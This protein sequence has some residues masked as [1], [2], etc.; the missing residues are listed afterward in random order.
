VTVKE[1]VSYFC[2]Q[3]YT[4]GRK[5]NLT[6]DENF[7]DAIEQAE[8]KDKELQECIAKGADPDKE[9]GIFFG[10]PFS[11]KDQIYVKGTIS[12]MGVGSRADKVTDSDAASVELIR[13]QGGIPF[14]KG[15][16]SDC[17]IS[18]HSQSLIWGSAKHP[19]DNERTVGGSSGGDA[20]LLAAGCSPF[21]LGSDFAGSIRIPSL[22]CGVYGFLPTPERHSIKG[23]SCYTKYDGVHTKLFRPTIGPM[24]RS[25]DDIVD[26]MRALSTEKVRDFDKTVPS[27]PFN[28]KLYQD[29]LN[30]KKLRIGI[31]KN[32]G[33]ICTLEKDALNAFED[34][35][36][37]FIKGGHQ[38]VEFEIPEL[39]QLSIQALDILLN[40]GMPLV[41]E[42]MA[43]SGD[44]LDSNTQVLLFMYNFL[45]RIVTKVLAGI[46]RLVAPRHVYE[47]LSILHPRKI[48]DLGVLVKNR[49]NSI[50]NLS[51][52]LS[53]LQLDC[54]LVPGFKS[55]AFK[56]EELRDNDAAPLQFML[57]NLLHFPVGAGK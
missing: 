33:D 54:L 53:T 32:M 51:D 56:I 20:G 15:N 22:F 10:I 43:R 7:D 1:V 17:C 16:L 44:P 8:L 27:L 14:V 28:E 47:L 34:A 4:T 18:I 29:T 36:E 50:Q 41:L 35:K 55:G 38:I 23:L 3:A 12:S 2:Q 13:A 31:V 57:F 39:H 48:D 45:P 37:A 46:A 26:G 42:E 9:L 6:A 52:Q 5:L 21:A 24:G 30:N 19:L 25:A 49:F 11:V 40:E